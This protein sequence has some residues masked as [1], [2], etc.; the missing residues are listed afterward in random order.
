MKLGRKNLCRRKY[1]RR[2]Q[3]KKK[4][5]SESTFLSL[6]RAYHWLSCC[7]RKRSRVLARLAQCSL[8]NGGIFLLSIVFFDFVLIP[9]LKMLMVL[10]LRDSATWPLTQMTLSWIF[11]TFWILPLFLLS[12][13]INTFFWQDIAGNWE[14]TM[15]VSVENN[16]LWIIQ[17][18]YYHVHLIDE[19]IFRQSN[20]S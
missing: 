6:C 5:R 2:N 10:I 7:F 14:T 16:K 15:R 8:L 9:A 12:K 13:I 11:S 20:S 19:T 3:T 17:S 1:H 4:R 18:S